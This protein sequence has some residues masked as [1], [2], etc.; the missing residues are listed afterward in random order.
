MSDG[1]ATPQ[2]VSGVTGSSSYSAI[3]ADKLG[4]DYLDGE[5]INAVFE[6]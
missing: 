4:D 5:V 3:H 6:F 1:S 2:V